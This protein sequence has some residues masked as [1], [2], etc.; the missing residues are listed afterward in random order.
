[1]CFDKSKLCAYNFL[2]KLILLNT[3]VIMSTRVTRSSARISTNGVSTQTPTKSTAV[4]KRRQHKKVNDVNNDQKRCINEETNAD[5]DVHVTPPKQRKSCAK[6]NALSPST[7]LHRL[8]IGEQEQ[9]ENQ[10]EKPKSKI[11]NARK[12]LNAAETEELYGRE[13]E[14][15]ELNEFLTSNITKKT[16]ASIYISGQPGTGKTAC[17]RKLLVSTNAKKFQKV[18]I[19]CI[20]LQTPAT[21][22][23][24]ICTELNLPVVSDKNVNLRSIQHYICSKS[25]KMVLLVLDEIDELIEKKQSILYTIFEWPALL[26]AKIILIGI[27]NSLDLTNRALSRLQTQSTAVKPRLMHFSPYT[28]EQIVD[29]FKNRLQAAGVL[30]IFPVATLQLM[31]AKVAAMS[32]DIRK[33]LDLGRRV[34]EKAKESN[35][36]F[37]AQSLN[38]LGIN[39]IEKTDKIEVKQVLNVLNDAYST[40]N[41][42]DDE[43]GDAIPL[44][45]KIL[46]CTLLL[47]LKQSKNK[48]ITV[49]RLREVYAK[50]C[51]KRGISALD[52]YELFGLCSLT[53]TKGIIKMIKNKVARQTKIQLQW[54]EDEITNV[55]KDKQLIANI[56]TDV[57]VLNK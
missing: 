17:I 23:R 36:N 1:M 40:A 32:G 49:G 27:A 31:S 29:I 26:N 19:N 35:S 8:S 50:V 10:P 25:N 24:T 52:E 6:A 34:V 53:E 20:K 54:D 38:D 45:E 7:L 18:Y 47:L 22:Y 3:I 2:C 39:E 41:K 46:V 48:D 33:A 11:D 28:K 37:N 42:W 16:S 44:Q 57:T 43:N 21:V 15:D 13:K 5:D 51:N 12:V 56:L 55:V 9:D 14:I 30:D 4:E